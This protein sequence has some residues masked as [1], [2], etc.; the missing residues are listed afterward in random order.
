MPMRSAA[1]AAAIHGAALRRGLK[2]LIFVVPFLRGRRSRSSAAQRGQ[3]WTCEDPS[4]PSITSAICSGERHD[5]P[6]AMRVSRS[7]TPRS[8]ATFAEQAAQAGR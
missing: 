7:A 8:S 2:V 3:V 5:A 4:C 6:G 1:A